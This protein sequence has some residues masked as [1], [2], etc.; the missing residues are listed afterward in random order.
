[1]TY[2]RSYAEPAGTVKARSAEEEGDRLAVHA[3]E[4]AQLDHIHS[5]FS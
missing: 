1:M 4:V 5:S 2:R 3:G